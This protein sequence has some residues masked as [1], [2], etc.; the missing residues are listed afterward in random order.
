M[1]VRDSKGDIF[2][3][4]KNVNYNGKIYTIGFGTVYEGNRTIKINGDYTDTRIKE[5]D[6]ENLTPKFKEQIKLAIKQYEIALAAQKN[7]FAW[8]GKLD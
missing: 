8:D 5:E 7:Y 1:I 4:A 6:V 2:S 3:M